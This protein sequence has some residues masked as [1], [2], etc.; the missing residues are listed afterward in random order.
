MIKAIIAITIIIINHI[1][2]WYVCLYSKEINMKCIQFCFHVPR[3]SHKYFVINLNCVLLNSLNIIIN[4]I[5]LIWLK[6]RPF[7][8]SGGSLFSLGF[9]FFFFFWGP[10]LQKMKI[11]PVCLYYKTEFNKWIIIYFHSTTHQFHLT[12]H[13]T[14]LPLYNTLTKYIYTYSTWNTIYWYEIKVK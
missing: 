12:L 8:Q 6:L 3:M 7:K 2:I 9:W 10:F 5:Q 14:Q 11:A 13:L 1:I 4:N